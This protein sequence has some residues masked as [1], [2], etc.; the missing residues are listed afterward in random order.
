MWIYL[1]V[2]LLR[3]FHLEIVS[4]LS[5]VAF[6]AVLKRF[7][8]KKGKVNMPTSDNATNFKGAVTKL[9]T[10]KKLLKNPN[11]E[12]LNLFAKE[13]I[14]WKFIPLRSPNFG[15]SCIKSFKHHL[16]RAVGNNKITRGH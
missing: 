5:A 14:T 13:F 8:K 2:W 3:P 15:G 16:L 7:Y 11:K 1:Y 4:D 9:N 6:I 12:L 10:F